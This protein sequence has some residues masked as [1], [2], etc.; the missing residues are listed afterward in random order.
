MSGYCA[1]RS[2]SAEFEPPVASSHA[3]EP[4]EGLIKLDVVVTMES[5]ILVADLV[6]K[7]FKLLDN[8]QPAEILSFHSF[9][10]VSSRPHPG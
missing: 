10:E 8:G 6:Q 9:N 3:T 7:D 5:G 1:A 4:A 2:P